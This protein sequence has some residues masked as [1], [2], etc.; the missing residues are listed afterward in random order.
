MIKKS[1]I[2]LFIGF[3]LG[4]FTQRGATMVM[5]FPKK[6]VSFS[7]FEA[8]FTLNGQ[9]AISA[10]VTRSYKIGDKESVLSKQTDSEGKVQ[11]ETAWEKFKAPF[12]AQ[13]VA[14]QT[15]HVSYQEKT[16]EVWVGAKMSEEEYAEFGGHAKKITCELNDEPIIVKQE[17]GLLDTSCKWN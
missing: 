11:F 8:T 10:T 14:K 12:I 2:I 15:I 3:V 13:F 5:F 9:P 7:G 17:I 6:V 1:L 16:Y 4:S